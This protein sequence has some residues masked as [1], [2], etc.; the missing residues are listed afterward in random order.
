MNKIIF[1]LLL[2]LI[3]NGCFSSRV[4]DVTWM[5]AVE[6]RSILEASNQGFDYCANNGD[7]FYGVDDVK[8]SVNS[9][10]GEV[11][12][13]CFPNW[14]EAYKFDERRNDYSYSDGSILRND[15][16][17]YNETS[18]LKKTRLAIE[19]DAKVKKL[20]LEFMCIELMGESLLYLPSDNYPDRAMFEEIRSRTNSQDIVDACRPIH[21]DYIFA[22]QVDAS[23][24]KC[25]QMGFSLETPDMSKCTLELIAADMSKSEAKTIVVDGSSSDSAIADELKQMNRRENK[26]YYE[27]MMRTG[28][29]M[30]TC[31]TWPDC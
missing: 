19:V 1:S 28:Y 9:I 5:T 2:L 11:Q 13:V 12:T 22:K 7:Y 29:D 18:G 31:Y 6:N 3:L 4:S 27:K 10:T 24:K 14:Q 26:K 23:Q 25:M 30:M 21:N 17:T 15:Y 8:D 16:T 20:D